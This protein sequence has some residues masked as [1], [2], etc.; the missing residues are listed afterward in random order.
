VPKVLLTNDDGIEAAGLQL[1]RRSLIEA[2]AQAVVVAPAF[3]RSGAAR[4]CTPRDAVQ[5]ERLPSE[6]G[7]PLFICDGTP[8]DC[9]RAGLF[10][11][12]A[13]DAD[14]V[15]AGINHGANLGDDSLYSGTLG[16]GIEAALLG[17][18]GLALSQQPDDGR[19]RFRDKGPHT[20]EDSA[21]I[22]AR[23][24][25]AMAASPPPGRAVVNVNFPARLLDQA[26]EITRLGCR[27][28]ELGTVVPLEV[29]EDEARMS[30][31]LYGTPE[32]PDPR[33]EEEA[34]TDFAA[35]RA[36]LISA[37]PVS[38]SWGEPGHGDALRS[39]LEAVCA[40]AVAAVPPDPSGA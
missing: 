12:L 40:T 6:D 7:H 33:H 13:H 35:L 5:I 25:R 26:I 27:Y 11:R 28:F 23:L 38:L 2:G 30:L 39:W 34:G 16:A 4:A 10:T 9:V 32:D 21:R 36:G 24:A 17:V 31:H 22:G 3:N 15:V 14:V 19:F 20:F 37:T 18:P 8:V 29:A 1:L